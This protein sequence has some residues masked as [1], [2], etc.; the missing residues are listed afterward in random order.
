[1]FIFGIDVGN[2]P[3]VPEDFY[4]RMKSLDPYFA[5]RFGEREFHEIVITGSAYENYE[6]DDTSQKVD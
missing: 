5:I 1:M 3:L 4:R 2:A 6:K